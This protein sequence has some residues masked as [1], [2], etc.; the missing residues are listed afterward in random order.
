MAL[1]KTQIPRGSIL[2]IAPCPLAVNHY[3]PGEFPLHYVLR[4]YEPYARVSGCQMRTRPPIEVLSTMGIKVNDFG[5]CPEGRNANYY[6]QYQVI[7]C[8]VEE[9]PY[10]RIQL[11]NLEVDKMVLE[12]LKHSQKINNY[13]V[14]HLMPLYH[15]PQLTHIDMNKGII[16]EQ[17]ALEEGWILV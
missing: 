9:L 4:L 14:E 5:P 2:W 13:D 15:Q 16:D 7:G 10:H 11:R 6:R 1:L 12:H 3:N 17:P 8:R